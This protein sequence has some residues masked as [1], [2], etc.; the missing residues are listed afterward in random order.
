MRLFFLALATSLLSSPAL[1]GRTNVNPRH[2]TVSVHA[3]TETL[4]PGKDLSLLFRFEIERGWH[5]YWKNPGDSGLPAQ[6]EILSPEGAKLAP[7]QWPT[8][9]RIESG[10]LTNFGFENE[11]ILL[12]SLSIPNEALAGRSTFE[13]RF[14]VKYLVC[15]EVCI[16]EKS[17]VRFSLPVA[18]SPANDN[19]YLRVAFA[20][21]ESH[22]EHDATSLLKA[23]VAVDRGQ[24]VFEFARA[25][26]TESIRDA[27][28]ETRIGGDLKVA[29]EIRQSADRVQVRFAFRSDTQFP[30][31]VAAVFVRPMRNPLRF[32]A[33]V[34][35]IS[36]PPQG[37]VLKPLRPRARITPTIQ[38]A[39]V[40]ELIQMLAF[41]FAGGLI[42]NLM[43]CVFPV[44]SLK[45]IQLVSQPESIAQKRL[46]AIGY[47]A[48]VIAT[49]VSLAAVLLVFRS[50]GTALGWGFQ[51]QSP[52]FVS[53]LALLFLLMALNLLGTFEINLPLFASPL[54]NR[55]HSLA[56]GAHPIASS[57][58]TGVLAVLVATP[59]TAPFMGVALGFALSQPAGFALAIFVALGLGLALPFVLLAFVPALARLFPRPGPWMIRLKEMLALPLLA[60]VVWLVWVLSRQTGERGVLF[61]LT[62]LAAAGLA[63]RFLF[64][65]RRATSLVFTALALASIL[66]ISTLRP[67]ENRRDFNAALP[68]ST[69]VHWEPF[70]PRTFDETLQ[71]DQFVFVDFTAAWCITC[72]V[73]KKI[74][75]ETAAVEK[76]FIKKNVKLIRADWTNADPAITRV[77]ARFGRNGVPLYL[78]HDPRKKGEP[79]ILPQILTP[80][81]LLDRLK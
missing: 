15:R 67:I 59:C 64:Q 61:A 75:L 2:V 18:S 48:G 31:K 32:E 28:L 11:L 47:T 10:P 33:N 9:E 42:L 7:L 22:A 5:T 79:E 17:E 23:N 63:S 39:S 26:D 3:K 4:Q 37:E 44:L 52:V 27:F 14:L 60:T 68:S 36:L 50:A 69:E 57:A 30:E 21:A 34:E 55:T 24:L 45:A 35:K 81:N 80:Q 51:L 54:V 58:L 38:S 76:A 62:C 70:D 78:W 16:P 74:A 12:T 19:A 53:S 20:E 46:E 6:V 49:F 1:A 41:A 40:I 77:L 72:Q 73:N 25:S 13:T 71:A 56:L 65:R 8:P 43:P 66:K 29:P